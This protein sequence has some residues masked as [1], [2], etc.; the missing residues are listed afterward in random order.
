MFGPRLGG[1]IS[2]TQPAVSDDAL[3]SWGIDQL[4]FGTRPIV[5]VATGAVVAEEATVQYADDRIWSQASDPSI[6]TL[7]GDPAFIVNT[8]MVATAA[9][10]RIRQFIAVPVFQSYLADDDFVES[11]KNEVRSGAGDPSKMMLI[12]GPW[13]GDVDDWPKIQR[14]RSHGIKVALDLAAGQANELSPNPE[15]DFGDLMRRFSFDLVR[16][17]LDQGTQA[18][19]AFAVVKMA[20]NLGCQAMADVDDEPALMA[21]VQELDVELAVG[22]PVFVSN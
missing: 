3:E 15:P 12:V 20:A 5:E 8:W 22:A 6:G 21:M 14:L 2:S 1:G 10:E 9:R 11:F 13:I 4:T 17:G 16:I 7:D 19:R 18:S